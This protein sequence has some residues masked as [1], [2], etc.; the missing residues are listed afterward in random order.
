[1]KK[2]VQRD[3]RSEG[4]DPEPVQRSIFPERRVLQNHPLH[5]IRVIVDRSLV[6]LGG[7]LHPTMAWTWVS[8]SPIKATV[9]M[10]NDVYPH[11]YGTTRQIRI[12]VW[13]Q[14]ASPIL[15]WTENRS[16]PWRC[17]AW[18]NAMAA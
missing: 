7:H 2:G 16:T 4:K 18:V 13:A 14:A 3:A 9:N 8:Y 17:R 12:P 5:A 1:M 10:S 15:S 6:E 11:I